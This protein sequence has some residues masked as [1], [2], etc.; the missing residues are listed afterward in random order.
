MSKIFMLVLFGAL[1]YGIHLWL[2]TKSYLFDDQTIARIAE[3]YFGLPHQD[4]FDKVGE[5]LRERYPGHILPKEREEWI[6]V[7]A[8]GWMGAM[9][10]VHASLTEYILFFGTAVD[11]SGHSGR[12]W[13]NVSDTIMTGNFRQWKEGTTESEE[14]GP[15]VTLLHAWGE[16]T[17]VQWTAGTWM[18]EYGRGFIPSTLPFAVSDTIFSTQDFYTLYRVVRIY[19]EALFQEL[20]CALG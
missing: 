7:N 17:S 14:Y 9:C 15:G 6:F 4:A 10:L 1:I 3:K 11:T 19:G 20:L 13:A 8:G 2:N 12:Y 18:V 5:V 16:A